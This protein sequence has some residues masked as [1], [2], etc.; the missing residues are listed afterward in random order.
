M[1]CTTLVLCCA[2]LCCGV[3]CGNGQERAL[4]R[5]RLGSADQGRMH[6]TALH[7]HARLRPDWH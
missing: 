4:Y 7:W 6:L 5:T 1:F 2:V 3:L